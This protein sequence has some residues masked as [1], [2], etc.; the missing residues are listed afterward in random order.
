MPVLAF[1]NLSCLYLFVGS[2]HFDWFDIPCNPVR[3]WGKSVIEV[4]GEKNI[5]SLLKD[6]ADLPLNRTTSCVFKD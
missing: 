3:R 6:R 5:S 4:L 1:H 2:K